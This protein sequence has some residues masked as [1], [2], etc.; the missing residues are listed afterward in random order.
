MLKVLT[1]AAIASAL[2]G[3]VAMAQS[4]AQTKARANMKACSDEWKEVK[5]A[6][7]PAKGEGRKAWSEF[8]SK[9]L[10]DKKG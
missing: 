7:P 9:C 2:F 5:K 10:K 1:V 4:D 3:G 8:R 6:N